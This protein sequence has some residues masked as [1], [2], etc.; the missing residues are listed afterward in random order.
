MAHVITEICVGTKDKACVAECPV[1]CIHE[2]PRML[3]IEPDECIDCTLC[4]APCPVDAIFQE[5]ELPLQWKGATK[6]NAEF[7]EKGEGCLCHPEE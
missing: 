6:E 3:Y 1:D 7:F 4:V 2:G 5:D